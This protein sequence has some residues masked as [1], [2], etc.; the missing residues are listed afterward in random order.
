MPSFIYHR[1][2]S[3]LLLTSL[4]LSLSLSF[5]LLFTSSHPRKAQSN[6]QI[7]KEVVVYS[8]GG[9]EVA[10]LPKMPADNPA[11]PDRLPFTAHS[12]V[13]SSATPPRQPSSGHVSRALAPPWPFNPQETTLI[14]AGYSPQFIPSLSS[15]PNPESN[16]SPKDNT[17]KMAEP[18]ARAPRQK[19][20]MNFPTERTCFPPMFPTWA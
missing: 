12:N 20:Q 11:H 7:A 4:C 19:G 9:R 1:D 10:K 14:K 13:Q 5:S 3:F 2:S 18:R 17:P 16:A 8:P 6:E 15:P